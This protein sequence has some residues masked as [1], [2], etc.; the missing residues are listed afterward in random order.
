[1]AGHPRL[2]LVALR[3]VDLTSLLA[4]LRAKL[5]ATG[6]VVLLASGSR[7]QLRPIASSLAARLLH[8]AGVRFV[9][10][11]P[12]QP[13]GTT[14]PLLTVEPIVPAPPSPLA[15]QIHSISQASDGRVLALDAG[16]SAVGRAEY[17]GGTSPWNWLGTEGID[18]ALRELADAIGWR[19]GVQY[20]FTWLP[21]MVSAFRRE[22]NLCALS[23]A[24]SDYEPRQG[25]ITFDTPDYMTPD[26][27]VALAEAAN[28]PVRGSALLW[29]Q[30]YPGWLSPQQR[31]T[32]EL[33][34]IIATYIGTV[35]AHFHGAVGQWIV[36]NEFI[37]LSYGVNDP[38]Q[39][40]LGPDYVDFAFAAARAAD[41]SVELLYNSYD[42]ETA[43]GFW[44]PTTHHLLI[45]LTPS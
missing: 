27:Q 4:V 26:H 7:V 34:Q 40:V 2:E 44:T 39:T 6:T 25:T 33:E 38:L 32:N 15:S 16:G 9:D 19:V 35:L 24:W 20:S 28:Q 21:Q 14:S 42:N 17:I 36:V 31:S 29:Y 30:A 22:F 37:P 45:R 41:P 18:W 5:D 43:A 23:A 3:A 1:V 8:A 13:V 11:A 12:I 10:R